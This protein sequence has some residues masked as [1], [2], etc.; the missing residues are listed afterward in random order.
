MEN[1]SFLTNAA[2]LDFVPE[3]YWDELRPDDGKD[4][5]ELE[6]RLRND[7]STGDWSNHR[8]PPVKFGV[9]GGDYL[10]EV[11]ELRGGDR[12]ACS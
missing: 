6:R 9:E 2:V 8:L 4:R 11:L 3:T 7:I 10:P 1:L 5:N 12:S